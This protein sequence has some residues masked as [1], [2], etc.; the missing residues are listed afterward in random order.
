[1]TTPFPLSLF[2]HAGHMG[3]YLGAGGSARFAATPQIKNESGIASH[4]A[5]KARGRQLMG[6]QISL[7]DRQQ[8]HVVYSLLKANN[9]PPDPSRFGR[10]NALSKLESY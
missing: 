6:T 2:R 9:I 5:T 7:H 3:Q 10:N 8:A 4:L 1:M